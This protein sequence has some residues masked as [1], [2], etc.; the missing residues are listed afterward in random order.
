MTTFGMILLAVSHPP[1][2]L[3]IFHVVLSV[4]LCPVVM[5][6]SLP[7]YHVLGVSWRPWNNVICLHGLPCIGPVTMRKNRVRAVTLCTVVTFNTSFPTFRFFL[8]NCKTL[9]SPQASKGSLVEQVWRHTVSSEI[10]VKW[11]LL[12][13]W[14]GCVSC[15]C[16]WVG[17]LLI[18]QVQ[19]DWSTRFRFMFGMV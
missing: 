9:R 10:T 18:N 15:V 6:T 5:F 13:G 7:C 1:V 2:C 3:L 4:Y 19:D 11:R 14:K 12:Y 17:G 8:Y 16:V